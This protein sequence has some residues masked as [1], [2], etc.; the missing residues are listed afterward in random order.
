M[1]ND[2]T[3]ISDL[4]AAI[5]S[6]SDLA[7]KFYFDG[8]PIN[9][10]Y[11][12]T[13]VRHATINSIDCG[14]N[15]KTEQWEEITVQLLDGL[16]NS[17]QG[18]MPASKFQA[19]VVAAMKSLPA[20]RSSYLFFEFA[21]NNG[22]I[23]KLSIESIEQTNSEIAVSLGSERAVCKPFQR[24]KQAMLAVAAGGGVATQ[25]TDMG[26]CS[27]QAPKNTGGCCG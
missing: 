27:N 7:L 20:D 6:E 11:H 23:R 8:S 9:P 15:S 3:S 2:H 18:H 14:K 10:G 24:A 13:E 12:V 4:T 5:E 21:P 19:I 22:P 17:E 1:A 25:S 26:C 16:P